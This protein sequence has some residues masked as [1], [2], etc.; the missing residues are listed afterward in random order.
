MKRRMKSL[1]I[2][3]ISAVDRPAQKG[4]LAAI[5][6]RDAPMAKGSAALTGETNGHTHLVSLLSWNGELNAG[7]TEH[8][9]GHSHPWV[10]SADGRI[11]LG[12]VNGHTHDVS[13][14]SK[15]QQEDDTMTEAE[16]LAKAQKDLEAANEKLAKAEADAKAAAE[17]AAADKPA[18]K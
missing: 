5:L 6:K 16:K 15:N 4:A 1:Q 14:V 13:V 7:M 2:D 18:D 17:K 8:S 9:D 3:E 12:T 10:R 11:V